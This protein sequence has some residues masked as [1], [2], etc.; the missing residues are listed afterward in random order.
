MLAYLVTLQICLSLET[1]G[2]PCVHILPCFLC[3]YHKHELQVSYTYKIRTIKV[4]Q[5]ML[6]SNDKLTLFYF[7]VHKRNCSSKKDEINFEGK[8]E[9]WIDFSINDH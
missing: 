8:F 3:D 5:V 1:I 2:N 6:L 9:V 4:F 7:I